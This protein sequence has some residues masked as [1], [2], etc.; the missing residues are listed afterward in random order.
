MILK[1]ISSLCVNVNTGKLYPVVI[2]QGTLPPAA[3]CLILNTNPYT[4]KQ[5]I[6]RITDYTVQLSFFD[7]SYEGATTLAESYK[8]ILDGYR[9]VVENMDITIDFD[10]ENDDFDED[11]AIYQKIHIYKILKK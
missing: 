10:N 6:A 9:G 7:K 2:P 3:C 5:S 1:A 8:T 4:P 11:L